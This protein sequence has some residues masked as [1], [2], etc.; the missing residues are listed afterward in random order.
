MNTETETPYTV[1]TTAIPGLGG[2]LEYAKNLPEAWRK[3]ADYGRLLLDN[4]PA[5]VQVNVRI[6]QCCLKCQG[7]GR[8][9]HKRN[10][11]KF[12]ECRACKTTG[13]IP[14]SELKATLTRDGFA[15]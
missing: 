4:D 12:T 8:I 7:A 6:F 10:R 5:R 3:A 15:T 9:Q 2:S 13:E 14:G 1:S 11:Y